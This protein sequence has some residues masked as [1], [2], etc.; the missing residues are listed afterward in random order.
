MNKENTVTALFTH[1]ALYFQYHYSYG[2]YSFQ[3]IPLL[4]NLLKI[5]HLVA[6]LFS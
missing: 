1:I 4:Q 5:S 3:V 6:V 2:D